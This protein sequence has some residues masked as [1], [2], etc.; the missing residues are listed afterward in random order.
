MAKDAAGNVSNS[1]S[2]TTTITQS[3]PQPGEPPPDVPA[4]MSV[5]V[6]KWFEVSEK[7]MGYETKVSG[8]ARHNETLLAY[9]KIYEWDP[10]NNI[11][12]ADRYEYDAGSGQWFTEPLDL[13]YLS[14]NAFDFFCSAHTIDEQTYSTYAFTARITGAQRRGS[15]EAR[16]KTLGGYYV[17]VK[18][19]VPGDE[20]LAGNFRIQGTLVSE[21]DVLVPSNL[22]K[23]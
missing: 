16:L 17:T 2:A 6:G 10:V 13:N 18:N 1:R 5:W 20:Y 14:G 9:I 12:K 3:Q 7:Y 19:G 4:D 21:W 23:N 15:L 11:L 8:F 22:F